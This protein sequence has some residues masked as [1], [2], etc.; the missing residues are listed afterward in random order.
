MTPCPTCQCERLLV[1]DSRLT[2]EGCRRR[3]EC[4]GCGWRG[5]SHETW[6]AQDRM[7]SISGKALLA[8]VA[9]RMGV[10]L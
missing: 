5:T 8:E 10:R 1:V 3:Y 6:S 9:T 2:D 7:E 4:Q